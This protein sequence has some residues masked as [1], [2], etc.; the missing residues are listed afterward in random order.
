[1]K[2]PAAVGIDAID[3][4]AFSQGQVKIY[5]AATEDLRLKF[6]F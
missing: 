1:M 3:R 4:I 5:S 6:L 2:D